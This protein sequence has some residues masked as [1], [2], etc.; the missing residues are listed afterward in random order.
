MNTFTIQYPQEQAQ[1][2]RHDYFRSREIASLRFGTAFITHRFSWWLVKICSPT[3][4]RFITFCSLQSK[5]SLMLPLWQSHIRK[6]LMLLSFYFLHAKHPQ[7]LQWFFRG[8]FYILFTLMDRRVFY[9]L[10]SKLSSNILSYWLWKSREAV[11]AAVFLLSNWL[12]LLQKGTEDSDIFLFLKMM[13]HTHL[14]SFI[15]I[16][17]ICATIL[18]LCCY[19]L[20]NFAVLSG[21]DEPL[22]WHCYKNEGQRKSKVNGRELFHL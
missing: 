7:F 14:Q 20:Y 22:I 15:I 1:E 21:G 2:H 12:S 17:I 11:C 8:L 18:K 3:F 5:S 6:H 4:F 19:F 13:S 16:T 9:I 10:S